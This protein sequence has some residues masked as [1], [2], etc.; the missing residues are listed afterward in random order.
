MSASEA[1]PRAAMSQRRRLFALLLAVTTPL[2]VLAAFFV[3]V[4]VQESKERARH[5][6]TAIAVAGAL[7]TDSFFDGHVRTLRATALSLA[8]ASTVPEPELRARLLRATETSSEWDGM[9]IAGP[10]GVIL[11]GSRE[12]SAG[13]DLSER[14]YL[15]KM[16]A[17]GQAVVSEG[18]VSIE[19]DPSV[20]IAMPLPLEDG[21]RGALIGQVKLGTLSAALTDLL[22]TDARV[23]LI[24]G[25]GQT[26]VH[27][28][29]D[30]VAVLLNVS[31]R[32]EVIAAWAGQTG[33]VEVERDG[34]DLFVASAPVSELGWAVTVS[35]ASSAVYS[36]ANAIALRGSIFIVLA[37]MVVLVGGWFLGGRL[38]RSYEAMHEAQ[39]A[40][41]FARERA[42][43]ALRSRDEF[44][45][46][47]SHELRNPVAAI[48]GF[49]QLM[50]RRL[51]KGGLTE[52]DMRDYIDN[53]A[54][55]GAYLS[56]LVED[57]LSVSRLEGGRL[58][59][60]RQ[61]VDVLS[62]LDRAAAEA[63][64]T[65]HPLRVKR[66]DEPVEAYVDAD[67]VTQILVNLLENASK[68]SPTASEILVEVR[69]RGGEVHIAITDQGIGLPEADL[70]RL[71]APF[72]RA[73]NARDANIPGLG[74]GLYVSRRLA[75][76]HGGS[77]L[78]ASAGEGK[79]STFTL[80]LPLSVPG[81]SA[82]ADAAAMHRVDEPETLLD[83]VERAPA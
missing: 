61:D 78:A 51:A 58:E 15:Q 46:I 12:T 82:E 69:L 2:V 1:A 75:E 28:D 32:P 64:L 42:E 65:G 73:A 10:D 13:T 39:L 77:L 27:P 63:P 38:N 80:A 8:D 22:V 68:Y 60:L 33:T 5:D 45:S 7:A 35:E 31:D 30:R 24:D 26:L 3:V 79:G 19:G 17:T 50:Q 21:T 48:R 72:A 44:I 14:A 47:A 59:L 6:A 54:T 34:T 56:R 67:R 41:A 52:K 55:S 53:I 40:E 36:S 70:A 25:A 20:L 76:A 4:S 81:R 37:V 57:L 71:F 43:S 18:I 29:Q 9:S 11:A 16:F 23:G 83:V 66:P 74:L 62:I 49:G